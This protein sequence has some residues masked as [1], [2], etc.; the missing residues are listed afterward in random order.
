VNTTLR[1]VFLGTAGSTPTKFRSLSSVAL[2][3]DGEV[4]LFDC[5]EGT[6]RQMMQYSVNISRIKAVFLS[7]IHGDHTIGLAGLVRTL[8]LNKRTFPLY[9]FIPQG[10]EK[11]L[12][13]LLGFDKA[14]ISYKIIIK[15]I[16]AGSIYAGKDYSIG[17]FKLSHTISTYG[18]VFKESDK[19]KFIKQKVKKLGIKGMEFKSLLKNKSIKLNGKLIKLKDVTTNEHGRKVA[20]ATDTRPTKETIKASLNADVLIHEST[21]AGTESKFAK[22]RS[23]STATEAAEIAKRAKVKRLI[24]THISA[25]YNDTSA[26][27]KDAKAVFKNTEVAKDGFEITL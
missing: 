1:L 7:H 14:L 20:Y 5:G 12:Q 23:H 21:Y 25:R 24:L 26:L 2:E 15:P 19:T 17:A 8:A 22:E 9:I 3:R 11:H 27:L 13:E 6:Q 4:F 10:N 16:K 18:F